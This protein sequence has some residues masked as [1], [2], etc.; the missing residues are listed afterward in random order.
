MFLGIFPFR[1]LG[2]GERFFGSVWM[3]AMRD[4]ARCP[5]CLRLDVLPWPRTDVHLSRWSRFLLV[6]GA[7]VYRCIPCRRYFVSFRSRVFGAAPVS[8]L[9]DPAN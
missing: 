2:C 8:N 7:H 5:K 4:Y 1:C 6:L 9:G 3:L